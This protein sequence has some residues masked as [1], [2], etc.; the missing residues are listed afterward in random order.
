[1]KWR[2]R[3]KIRLNIQRKT[4]KCSALKDAEKLVQNETLELEASLEVKL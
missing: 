4:I 3:S 1:M 2:N